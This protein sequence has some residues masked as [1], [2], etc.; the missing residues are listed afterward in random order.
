MTGEHDRIDARHQRL[1]AREM[2]TVDAGGAA[3]G[4]A[5]AMHRDGIDRRDLG[6]QL[7]GMRVGDEILG[8]HLEPSGHRPVAQHA[9]EMRQPEADACGK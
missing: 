7:R 5:H 3:H 6:E 1:D 9:G 4:N 8:M 2:S